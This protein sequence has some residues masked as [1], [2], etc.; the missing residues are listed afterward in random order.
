MLA[1]ELRAGRDPGSALRCAAEVCAELGPVVQ[2]YDLGADV[3]H[4]LRRSGVPSLARVA[5]AWHVSHTSGRGLSE[6][7]RAVSDDLRREQ[8]TRRVVAA[9][10]ASA[11]ATAR[12]LVGL[13]AVALAVGTVGGAAP[14]R[15]F[16]SGPVGMGCALVGV[17]LLVAGLGWIERIADSVEV[18]A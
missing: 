4:A 2:A 12:L 16:V 13:P 9:E 8:A 3:P 14:W 18:Q 6:T 5:G 15:F 10:L 1:E 11:R 7:L 17:G